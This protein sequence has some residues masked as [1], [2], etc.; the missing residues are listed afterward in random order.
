[1]SRHPEKRPAKW[2]TENTIE[3]LKSDEGKE[4]LNST[5]RETNQ[6]SVELRNSLKVDRKILLEPV[7]L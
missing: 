3:W 4:K 6:W 7:T 1:M 5:F 2:P